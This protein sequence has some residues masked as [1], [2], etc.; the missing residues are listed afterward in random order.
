MR[1]LEERYA[2]VKLM[3]D[4]RADRSR[5]A[6]DRAKK[7]PDKT[8]LAATDEAG[9]DTVATLE[10]AGPRKGIRGALSRLV[11][12]G[13]RRRH[14]EQ[15]LETKE[16]Y[17]SHLHADSEG[18]EAFHN[19]AREIMRECRDLSRGFDYRTPAVPELS[20]DKIREARDHAVTRTG[21]EREGWLTACTQSQKLKDERD[22][23]AAEK[24]RA[25]RIVLLVSRHRRAPL[26][27]THCQAQ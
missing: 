20:P 10:Q 25:E 5:V 2:G 14:R 23:T 1:S 9:R 19:A 22:S 13:D 4:V 15:L 11:E 16:A 7:E 12:S 24:G 6:L 18:R 17:L 27:M 3:A 21:S 26:E 8:P